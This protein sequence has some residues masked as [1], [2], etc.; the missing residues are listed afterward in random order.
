MQPLKIIGFKN[1]KQWE[2]ITFNVDQIPSVPIGNSI[3]IWQ[4]RFSEWQALSDVLAAYLSQEEQ[5]RISQFRDPM[6]A[7]HYII[8]RGLLR[9]LLSKYLGIASAKIEISKNTYGKP[10][11]LSKT[12]A[13]L[14][15]N[16]AHTNDTVL[17]GFTNQH[18]IGIDLENFHPG[19]ISSLEVRRILSDNEWAYWQHLADKERASMFYQ[20]WVRKKSVLKALGVGLSIEPDTFSVGFAPK[21]AITQLRGIPLCLRDLWMSGQTKAAVVLISQK[22]SDIQYY[23]LSAPHA[24]R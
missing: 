20:T 16:L 9:E 24:A 10:M 17:Y 5:H 23:L 4:A 1:D 7:I 11:I 15:F 18:S 22:I 3:H 2:P 12:G 14:H 8:G 6:L 19:S 21:P 13:K